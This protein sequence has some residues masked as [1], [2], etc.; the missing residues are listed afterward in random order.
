MQTPS[1]STRSNP[2]QSQSIKGLSKAAKRII[3]KSIHIRPGSRDKV[4]TRN[5]EG[6]L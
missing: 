1:S 3:A 5:E 2:I 6:H 4:S